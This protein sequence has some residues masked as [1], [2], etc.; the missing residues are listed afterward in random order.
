MYGENAKYRLNPH[1]DFQQR[2]EYSDLKHNNKFIC[3][4]MQN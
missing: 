3:G 2:L 1:L 4:L